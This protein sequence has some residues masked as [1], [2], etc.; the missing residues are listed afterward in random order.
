MITSITKLK[1]VHFRCTIPQNI[2]FKLSLKTIKNNSM[3]YYTCKLLSMQKK[4]SVTKNRSL[5]RIYIQDM[6]IN[7]QRGQ[8][9]LSV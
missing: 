4:S 6:T 3:V 7:C 9:L 2:F 8:A 1:A 5:Y